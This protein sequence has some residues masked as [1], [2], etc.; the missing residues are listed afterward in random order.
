MASQASI[1]ELGSSAREIPLYGSKEIVRA[2]NLG[3]IFHSGNSQVVALSNANLC[4]AP[5]EMIA[6]VGPSGSGKSTLL[7][8]LAG[9]DTPTSGTVYFADRKS[10]RLNS[11]HM[12]IS[13]A[14]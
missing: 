9:L 1:T 6:L 10:T 8:L 14:V 12:S 3:R 11:S 4:V 2:E 13:Y 5:G 7:H